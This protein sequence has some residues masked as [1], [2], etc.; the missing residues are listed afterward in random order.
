MVRMEQI[1]IFTFFYFIGISKF[2]FTIQLFFNYLYSLS[3]ET[4]S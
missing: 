2:N 4:L 1:L 3:F